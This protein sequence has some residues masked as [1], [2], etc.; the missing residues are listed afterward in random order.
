MTVKPTPAAHVRLDRALAR[1]PHA[2]ADLRQAV[3]ALDSDHAAALS[4]V[5]ETL[6]ANVSA[7]TSTGWIRGWV[8]GQ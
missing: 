7:A 4:C 2:T 8:A 3:A 1:C 5:I 6:L